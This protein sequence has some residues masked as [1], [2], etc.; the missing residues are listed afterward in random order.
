MAMKFGRLEAENVVD[1]VQQI[2]GDAAV[3]AGLRE[4]SS[5]GTIEAEVARVRNVVHGFQFIADANNPTVDEVRREVA[6]LRRQLEELAADS[7]QLAPAREALVVAE[8][9]L[10][11]AEPAAGKR[12][13]GSLE[14]AATVLKG[15]ASTLESAD[16][17]ATVLGKLVPAA[18]LLKELVLRVAGVG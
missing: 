2:G 5:G 18:L 16:K 9:E 6:A 7:A 13:A 14:R 4:G 1:G 11:R 17:V 12:A 10:V 8:A 15:G 3:T